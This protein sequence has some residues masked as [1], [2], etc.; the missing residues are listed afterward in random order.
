MEDS[1]EEFEAA[2]EAKMLPCFYI[3]D[4]KSTNRDA[5]SIVCTTRTIKPPTEARTSATTPPETKVDFRH[6]LDPGLDC[7]QRNRTG[8][9]DTKEHVITWSCTD[10]IMDPDSVDGKR[11]DE[12]GRGRATGNGEYV[13]SLKVGDVVTV[14]GKARYGG[15]VNNVEEVKIDVYWA[16]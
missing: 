7:L 13:R 2:D 6:E 10:N 11:L 15:W 16:V 5:E 3:P 8:T 1:L 4:P 9:R 12:E 14:W